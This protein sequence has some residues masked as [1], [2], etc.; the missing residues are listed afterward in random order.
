M[1][2][3]V[4][5]VLLIIICGVGVTVAFFTV[6]A[7][8]SGITASAN[9]YTVNYTKGQDIAGEL[10]VGADYTS[11]HST[12]VVMYSDPSCE[13]L[14]GNLYITTNSESNMDLTDQAL[15]YSVVVNNQVVSEGY[16]NG[17]SNQLIYSKFTLNTTATTYKV[18]LWLD[19]SKEN[20]QGG[21]E[22]YSGFI[23]ADV[24]MSA[25]LP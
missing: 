4:I 13:L 6:T 2:L 22:S 12:D 23:H 25:V 3:S 21:N 15:R 7:S 8:K 10:I 18:Y 17:T 5:I 1:I 19:A 16:V 24:V 9:C 14:A 20:M 11:G